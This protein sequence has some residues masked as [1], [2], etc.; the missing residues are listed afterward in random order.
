[1]FSISFLIGGDGNVY[2]GRGWN[3]Q[4]AHTSNY[5]D[6]GYGYCFIGSYKN[7]TPVPA[8]QDAYFQLAQVSNWIITS[9]NKGTS[10]QIFW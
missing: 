6:V 7:I 4:G 2:E 9:Y 1:M 3:V 8:A 10:F 5:N